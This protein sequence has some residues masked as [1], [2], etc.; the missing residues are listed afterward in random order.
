MKIRAFGQVLVAA[1]LVG[2]NLTA[3]G[4]SK[5]AQCSA[6]ST[7]INKAAGLGKKFEA[8][9]QDLESKGSKIKKIEEFHEMAKEGSEK[10]TVLV[11]ELDNFITQ[12]KGVELKDEKL[13]ASRD[14]AVS[15]YTGASKSLKDVGEVLGEFTKMEAN[16]AGKKMLVVSTKKLETAM[17]DLQTVDKEEQVF[18]KDL[19][20]YCGVEKK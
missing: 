13:V 16:E 19:N 4:P 12:V 9:G 7:E 2:L 5:V 17:K 1:T 11:K 10:V 20:T 14:K 18:A 15:L 8:V 3:C 6:L